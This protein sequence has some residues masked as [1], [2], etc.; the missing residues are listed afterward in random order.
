[1]KTGDRQMKTDD[2]PENSQQSSKENFDKRGNIQIEYNKAHY[3]FIPATN[4]S[5]DWII[6]NF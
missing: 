1:M 3:F 2:H 5:I 6:S 4:N